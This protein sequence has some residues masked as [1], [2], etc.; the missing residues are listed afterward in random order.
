M[1]DVNIYF[2]MRGVNVSFFVNYCVNITNLNSVL[3]HAVVERQR[4][5]TLD[6]NMEY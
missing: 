4:A 5:K 2:Y 3:F 1:S 6:A